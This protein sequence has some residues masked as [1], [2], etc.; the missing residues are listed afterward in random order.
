[1]T[2]IRKPTI[3]ETECFERTDRIIVELHAH[4]LRVRLK[5]RSEAFLIDYG[6]LLAHGRRMASRAP[7]RK[8]G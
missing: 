3:R 5:G 8:V 6:E 7:F 4:H 1:M 2:K